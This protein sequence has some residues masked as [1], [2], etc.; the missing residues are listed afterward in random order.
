VLICIPKKIQNDQ[1]RYFAEFSLAN[2]LVLGI[3]NMLIIPTMTSHCAMISEKFQDLRI[4][5]IEI[6]KPCMH[7][8]RYTTNICCT[9]CRQSWTVI[10]MSYKR[11]FRNHI[12]KFDVILRRICI[13]KILK[14]LTKITKL[15]HYLI[16]HFGACTGYETR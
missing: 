2:C 15:T 12:T 1:I 10:Y 6:I 7:I 16:S 8:C 3:F 9:V 13:S 5:C 11:F 14:Y 4:S